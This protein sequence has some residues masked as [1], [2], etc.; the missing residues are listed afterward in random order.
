MRASHDA[1]EL[2]D[3]FR[4]VR[5]RTDRLAAPLFG[6]VEFLTDDNEDFA[7]ALARRT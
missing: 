7:L 2:L 6:D 3:R 4:R 5:S 1:T